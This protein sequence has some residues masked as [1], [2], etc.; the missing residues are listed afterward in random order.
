MSRIEPTTGRINVEDALAHE[1]LAPYHDVRSRSL[2]RVAVLKLLAQAEDEPTADPLPSSFFAFDNVGD[3]PL[4]RE[5]LKSAFDV[6]PSLVLPTHHPH[7]AHLR[8]D[9]HA[10]DGRRG[11]LIIARRSSPAWTRSHVIVSVNC[12]RVA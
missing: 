5:E 12:S 8:R 1:F 7:R 9:C 4:S 3:K 10:S 11:P 6:C 2:F